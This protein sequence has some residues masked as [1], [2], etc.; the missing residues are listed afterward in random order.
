MRIVNSY[1]SLAA[2]TNSIL[3]PVWAL[4]LIF[5]AAS[6]VALNICMSGR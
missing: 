3:F 1:V 5:T 4:R 2:N 6:T